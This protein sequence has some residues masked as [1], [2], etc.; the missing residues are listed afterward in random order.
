MRIVLCSSSVWPFVTRTGGELE[1]NGRQQVR[2]L[3]FD[4]VRRVASGV[5]RDVKNGRRALVP[6]SY[7]LE[8]G[9]LEFVTGFALAVQGA[10]LVPLRVLKGLVSG[11]I[12]VA[13]FRL[14]L[15]T[16]IVVS[17]Y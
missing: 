12:T 4:D 3:W 10:L 6:Q 13:Y 1:E 2:A 16:S 8:F 9:Q 14:V 15:S 11:Q 5:N 17:S 7:T